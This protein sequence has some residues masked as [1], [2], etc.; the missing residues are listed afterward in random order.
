MF[1]GKETNA[2][3]IKCQR[4]HESSVVLQERLYNAAM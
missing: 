1:D 2:N 3:V 4:K